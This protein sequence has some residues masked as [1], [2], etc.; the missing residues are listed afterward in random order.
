MIKI[1]INGFGRIGRALSRINLKHQNFKI[2]AINDIDNDLDNLAYLLKYDSTYGKLREDKVVV[3]DG[4]LV[5]NGVETE[6][7][8]HNKISDVPWEKYDVDVVIDS[9]G[10]FQNVLDSKVLTDEKKVKKVIITHSPKQGL[11]YT[12]MEGVN[13]EFYDKELHNV[14]SSSICDANAVAPFYKLIDDNFGVELG[15]VTTLH[16]WLSYQNLVDGTVKSV[17]SPG[18]TWDN[19]ALGRN[20]VSSLIPKETSLCSALDLILPNTSDKVHAYSFRTPTSI[21]SVAEGVFLLKE[22][23]NLEAIKSSLK[24]YQEKYPNVLFLDGRELV[25]IDYLAN[26]YGAVVDDRSLFLNKG[27]M[28]K[29]VLWYDNEWGYASR[30]YNMIDKI[31]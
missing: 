7:F 2:V 17:S 28:L 6:V 3:N 15:E 23:T 21:V 12:Y 11:D 27:K 24:E 30:A 10:V 14:I 19:Y 31:L 16:P 22:K 5:I 13:E 29:F 20:S 8:C 25:S 4:K 26:E 9:S 18:H 1:G